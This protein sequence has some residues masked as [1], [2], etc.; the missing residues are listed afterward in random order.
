M[1]ST[2]ASGEFI[3][4][5]CLFNYSGFKTLLGD[6]SYGVVFATR[7]A[8]KRVAVKVVHCPKQWRL[9]IEKLEREVIPLSISANKSWKNVVW[10]N[11][12][13]VHENFAS[14]IKQRS[15]AA[16]PSDGST[17][18]PSP[19]HLFWKSLGDKLT[20]KKHHWSHVL[21]MEMPMAEMSLRGQL[22][23]W[24][25]GLHDSQIM[26]AVC[27]PWTSARWFA[28]LA[29]GIYELHHAGFM[30][31]DLKPENCLLFRENGLQLRL[32]ISDLGS[33]SNFLRTKSG[34]NTPGMCTL[35]YRAPELLA[36]KEY[37][38]KMDIWSAGTIFYELLVGYPPYSPGE[39]ERDDDDFM[40]SD[41]LSD[42]PDDWTEEYTIVDEETI[43]RMWTNDAAQDKDD[44]TRRQQDDN[45]RGS[46]TEQASSQR[47]QLHP[48]VYT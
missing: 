26:P 30:H 41:A 8:D 14:D 28:D 19:Q 36:Q 9:H 7:V 12:A 22:A 18:A 31:R 40:L 4:E 17:F 6:G 13:F 37:S 25:Q 47:P 3:N 33:S 5:G 23:S 20:G 32:R 44:N 10:A 21:C 45:T 24:G 2:L 42:H 35:W 29:A 1:S 16:A 27:D 48:L 38:A 15:K 11:H 43:F 46:A 34:V 39:G